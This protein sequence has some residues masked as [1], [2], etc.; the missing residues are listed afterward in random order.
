VR[1]LGVLLPVVAGDDDR[2]EEPT[3]GGVTPLEDVP[4][5][6]A[7]GDCPL[8]DVWGPGGGKSAFNEPFGV[9]SFLTREMGLRCLD[10]TPFSSSSSHE[11]GLA[12]AEAAAD[13]KSSLDEFPKIYA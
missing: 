11:D 10:A 1:S 13:D 6:L 4:D 7:A 3:F 2:V 8:T 12:R 5:K 9:L